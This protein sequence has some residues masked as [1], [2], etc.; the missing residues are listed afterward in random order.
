MGKRVVLI[1]EYDMGDYTEMEEDGI[2][3][4][5]DPKDWCES[6]FQADIFVCDMKIIGVKIIDDDQ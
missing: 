6:F 2:K 3:I 1:L 4:S 5:T